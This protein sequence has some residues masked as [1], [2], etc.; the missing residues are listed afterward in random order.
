MHN[1]SAASGERYGS[2]SQL[3]NAGYDKLLR[4][5]KLYLKLQ[6]MKLRQVNIYV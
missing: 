6:L 1:N 4:M 3:N 2:L 5:Y